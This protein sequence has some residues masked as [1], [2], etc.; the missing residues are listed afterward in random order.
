MPQN[1]IYHDGIS[2]LSDAFLHNKNLEIL[3][4]ND[5][6]IGPKGSESIAKALLGL[7]NIKELNFGDCLL[8]TK[9]AVLLA[10]SLKAGNKNLEVLVLGFNEIGSKGGVEL[11][12]AMANKAKLKNLLLDGNQ[13][14][15]QG[16]DAV[17]TKMKEVGKLNCLGSL[18]EDESEDS[19]EEK[20]EHSEEESEEDEE[21]SGLVIEEVK[22]TVE[23][24]L[25]APSEEKLLGLED[26]RAELLLQV[27]KVRFVGCCDS[28]PIRSRQRF[29][30]Q[31]CLVKKD[32][33][34]PC[35]KTR[36]FA[37]YLFKCE[38]S[39][40]FFLTNVL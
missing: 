39:I 18:S 26:S 29:T 27:A 31:F 35:K 23:E 5:N 4:L 30:F 2:A 36:Y 17:K 20:S 28:F 32:I 6:T 7:E 22:F 34:S 14:G 37:L 15:N 40:D 8:K 13:F 9:G 1:G 21:K 16:R 19:E 10:N 12:N 25:E 38:K 3:N 24:F 11:V 33:I